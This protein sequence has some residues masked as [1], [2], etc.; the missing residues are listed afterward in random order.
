MTISGRFMT[1][2]NTVGENEEQE[3]L[4]DSSGRLIAR[5]FVAA[6]TATSYRTAI[7]AA[8]VVAA[9]GTVTCTKQAGGACI[10]G[11]YNVKVVAVNAY[12]RTTA[13]AGNVAVTTETTNLT[14]RAAF[15]AVTN[16]THYD[17]YVSTDADPKWVGR[18]TEA[19]RA[20]GIK[21]D[22]VGSTAAGGTAGA[23]D[24]E[25][26]GTGLQAATTAATNTAYTVASLD[27]ITPA[28][29]QHLDLNIKASRT[30]DAV[31]L[32]L[33]VI[34]FFAGA[35][36]LYYADVS[37]YTLVF[38]GAS[39]IYGSLYQSLRIECRGRATRIVVASIAGTGASVD[40]EYVLS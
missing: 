38:G 25:V 23:V 3:F 2:P 7:T 20:S 27:D 8:D 30:G 9:P 5:A 37:P 24:V 1:T 6:A 21:I 36:G 32:S 31:A 4:L 12:G 39:G 16:A 13:T 29:Q 17:V 18:I 28:G 15:A 34:P 22:A 40:L 33:I 35:S 14:V 26:P 11:T 10:A 19:Q